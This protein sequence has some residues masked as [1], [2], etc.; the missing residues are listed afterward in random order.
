M[1]DGVVRNFGTD[2]EEEIPGERIRDRIV[3]GERRSEALVYAIAVPLEA[4]RGNSERR[5][6]RNALRP[7]AK[8]TV[9]P[10][11]NFADFTDSARL[12]VFDSEASFVGRVALVAHLRGDLGLLG[13]PGELAR[14]GYGP[15]E[16][17][18]HVDVLAEFHG[19]E[20]DGRVHV[21]GRSDDDGVDVLLF[22]EHLAIV[23]VALGLLPMFGVDALHIGELLFR[24][25]RVQAG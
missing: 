5:R 13:F 9:G 21:I 22:F 15:R 10:N 6:P 23:F 14:F 20:R 7:E 16:R 17:L 4:F 18:L 25:R 24:R 1:I 2:A 11:V 8:R 12:N 19:R 3:S